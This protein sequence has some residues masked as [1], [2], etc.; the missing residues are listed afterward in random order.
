MKTLVSIL[1]FIAFTASS[2]SNTGSDNLKNYA[3]GVYTR[4][5]NHEHATGM[6]TLTISLLDK[7]T[8]AFSI[9]KSSGFNT[10][11]D[12]KELPREYKTEKFITTLQ[13]EA[14]QLYDKN[15]D[16][17]FTLLPEKNSILMGTTEYKKIKKE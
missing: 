16:E 13:D 2:C 4:E 10:K 14:K 12:G 15:K 1:F 9:V 8:G 11:I 6:D 17:T 7:E 5:I 3:P